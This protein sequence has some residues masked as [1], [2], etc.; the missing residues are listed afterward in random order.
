MSIVVLG[1]KLPHG[2]TLEGSQ[3]QQITI[4]G[5]NTARIAGGFG[6]THVDDAEWAFLQMKYSDFTP[7]I[8]KAIFTL[9]DDDVN[10]LIDFGTDLAGVKTGFE[11]MD[12]EKPAPGLKVAEEDAGRIKKQLQAPM[13]PPVRMPKGAADKAAAAQ[14]VAAKGGK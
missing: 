5:T 9:G 8:T 3:D 2:I 6:I 4:N 14:L 7:I 1:C 12:A 13:Q 11:G 10:S